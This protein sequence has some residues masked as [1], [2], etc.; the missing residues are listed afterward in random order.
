MAVAVAASRTQIISSLFAHRLSLVPLPPIPLAPC[1]ACLFVLL[2][3]A[4]CRSLV[5]KTSCRLLRVPG[6]A[7]VVQFGGNADI[8]WPSS[9]LSP[10]PPLSLSL[11]RSFSALSSACGGRGTVRCCLEN[12]LLILSCARCDQL[13]IHVLWLLLFSLPLRAEHVDTCVQLVCVCKCYR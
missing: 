11:S 1:P 4:R 5:S 7:S 2:S 9:V 13:L 10:P 8:P 3:V 6:T 12:Y